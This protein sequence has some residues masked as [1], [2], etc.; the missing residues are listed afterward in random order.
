MTVEDIVVKMGNLRITIETTGEG[1]EAESD[2]IEHRGKNEFD[3]QILSA[4]SVQ[5]LGEL[6]L[7]ELA[8]L[9]PIA[10][11]L[12]PNSVW[13]PEARVARA[14]QKGVMSRLGVSSGS[15]EELPLDHM[16]PAISFKNCFYFCLQCPAHP[17]GFWTSSGKIMQGNT[18]NLDLDLVC[19]A[20]ASRAEADAFLLGAKRPWPNQLK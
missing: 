14:Y 20:C 18:A 8:F 13:S 9:K 2:N 12:H 1:T 7:G 6:V 16:F 3:L 10:S 5:D 19:F 17:D 15:Q 4:K 11:R